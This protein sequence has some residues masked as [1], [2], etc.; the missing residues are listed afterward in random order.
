MSVSLPC[1]ATPPM[2]EEMRKTISLDELSR[3][4]ERIADDIGASGAVYRIE[5]RGKAGMMLMDADYYEG[6][7]AA[8][9][10]MKQ[11]DW[12]AQWDRALEERASGV[13]RAL[14]D[15]ATELGLDRPAQPHRRGT[16]SRA[17][18]TRRSKGSRRT[19]RTR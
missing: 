10:L 3:N 6:W 4:A 9:E 19:S 11:P 15:V 12:R 2:L 8:I 5:R 14:D 16:A 18:T 13:G 7:R 17:A 1:P